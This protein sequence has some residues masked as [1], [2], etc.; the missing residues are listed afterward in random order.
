MSKVYLICEEVSID[1]G[2][3]SWDGIRLANKDVY[4][5]TPDFH[6]AFRT[7]ADTQIY[8]KKISKSKLYRYTVVGVDFK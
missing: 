7:K 1:G 5:G 3:D 2:R 4:E 6:P 8:I